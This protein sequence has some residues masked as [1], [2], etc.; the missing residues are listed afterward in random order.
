MTAEAE[1]L[2]TDFAG[3]AYAR[4]SSL[5]GEISSN[6]LLHLEHKHALVA[7]SKPIF[8]RKST[9]PTG[10]RLQCDLTAIAVMVCAFNV[11]SL[12]CQKEAH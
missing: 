5:F 10:P 8:G 6:R 11:T 9:G 12:D 2:L 3:G 4:G 7:S 1:L